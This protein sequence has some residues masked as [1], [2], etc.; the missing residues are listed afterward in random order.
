LPNEIRI[1]SFFLS[2]RTAVKQSQFAFKIATS[3]RPRSGLLAMTNS[4]RW[5][6]LLFTTQKREGLPTLL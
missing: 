2:L 3:S 5:P 6:Y 4:G 1:N